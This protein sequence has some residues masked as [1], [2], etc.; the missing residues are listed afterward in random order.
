MFRCFHRLLLHRSP[1]HELVEGLGQLDRGRY[2]VV[3]NQNSLHGLTTSGCNLE[4]PAGRG[5]APRGCRRHWD[6]VRRRG[7]RRYPKGSV[8]NITPA[9]TTTTTIASM[10]TTGAGGR[11][12]GAS[13]CSTGT[14][15]RLRLLGA[16]KHNR[17]GVRAVRRPA[18]AGAAARRRRVVGTAARSQ[19]I[20][21]YGL[22]IGP[23]QSSAAPSS[24]RPQ[25]LVSMAARLPPKPGAAA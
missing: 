14:G 25:R 5:E 9:A 16:A 13:I 19:H 15:D 21:A 1:C 20:R 11:L 6:S 18:P 22:R 2:L 24:R 10:P 17:R 7:R 8:R 4:N 23:R 3:E 12:R